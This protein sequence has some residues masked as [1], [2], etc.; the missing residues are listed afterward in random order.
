MLYN[1]M[2]FSNAAQT[3][4]K[5]DLDHVLVR[6]RR[7]NLDHGLTGMLVYVEGKFSQRKE[8]RFLQ[9]LEGPKHEVINIFNSIKDDSRHSQVTLLQE[10]VIS[11]RTFSSWNMGFESF[12]LQLHPELNF[13][14]T[15]DT[16]RLIGNIKD[17]P[18]VEFLKSFYVFSKDVN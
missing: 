6:S 18:V 12:D 3:M 17:H 7:W 10:G 15:L 13:F 14:F 1:L 2:Y 9:I 8:G 11:K 5:E 4:N 16:Q